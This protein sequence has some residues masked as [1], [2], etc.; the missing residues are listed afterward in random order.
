MKLLIHDNYI[1]I[2]GVS[3]PALI[4]NG[5]YDL[6]EFEMFSFEYADHVGV[7]VELEPKATIE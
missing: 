1:Q 6:D 7:K 4:K 5:E 3:I 2:L